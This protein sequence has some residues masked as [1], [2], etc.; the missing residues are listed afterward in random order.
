MLSEL[1]IWVTG[2]G[3]SGLYAEVIAFVGLSLLTWKFIV[4]PA[5]EWFGMMRKIIYEFRPNG[6]SSMKDALDRIEH[7]LT[8]DFQRRRIMDMD[9]PNGIF[10]TDINGHFK[11]VNRT[12]CK[13]LN[14]TPEELYGN[15]WV[16]CISPAQRKDVYAE[17]TS[18]INQG[19][20]FLMTVNLLKSD[21]SEV[22]TS[23]K[24]MAIKDMN[25]DAI[26]WLGVVS[27]GSEGIN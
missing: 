16:S 10:E 13:M 3:F 12:L 7:K 21:G 25:G 9:A 26:E 14:R 17:W 6:G 20:E 22:V 15:G 11:Y 8:V 18:A 27:L 24:A 5:V 19:R 1:W 23:I 4:K 2:S